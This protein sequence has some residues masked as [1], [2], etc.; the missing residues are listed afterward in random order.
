M[1]VSLPLFSRRR[2]ELRPL[3][4]AHRCENPFFHVVC[5][6]IIASFLHTII[7]H[8]IIVLT[9]LWCHSPWG[10][11]GRACLGKQIKETL[12][13]NE[14]CMNL[15]VFSRVRAR[16]QAAC[17]WSAAPQ[18]RQRRSSPS[19]RS[20][21]LKNKNPKNKKQKEIWEQKETKPK[22]KPNRNRNKL[23]SQAP[24]GR[25]LQLPLE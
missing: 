19:W 16:V 2:Q 8:T 10:G 12:I 5:G 24:D 25:L 22:T 15:I 18:R 3:R 21:V 6:H 11:R 17:P 20:C 4:R 9:S 14:S 13:S 23:P 7:F 1:A